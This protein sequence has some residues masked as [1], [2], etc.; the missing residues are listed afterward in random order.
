MAYNS[1]SIVYILDINNLIILKCLRKSDKRIIGFIGFSIRNKLIDNYD[2]N[3][4]R[5]FDN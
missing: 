1:N 4:V 2:R 5:F 3:G